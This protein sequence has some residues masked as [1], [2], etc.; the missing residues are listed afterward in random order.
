MNRTIAAL[1]QT[2]MRF[3]GVHSIA[4]QF[5]MT[6]V[7]IFGFALL[8]LMVIYFSMGA[9]A[10]SMNLAGRQRM[11][12]QMAAKEALLAAVQKSDLRAVE[13]HLTLFEQSHQVLLSGDPAQGVRAAT[14]P[15]IIE[16][17]RAIEPLWNGYKRLL[18]DHITTPHSTHYEQ[19]AEQSKRLLKETNQTVT[20]MNAA[21]D[22]EQQVKQR[23]TLFT[24][25][26]ILILVI[27]GRIF[28]VQVLMRPIEELRHHLMAV[29]QGDYSQ[30][31]Q[32][33]YPDDEVGMIVR[34]YNQ[35]LD[36]THTLIQEI[37]RAAAQVSR[38]NQSVGTMLEQTEAGVKQQQQELDRVAKAMN[39]MTLS[40][41]QISGLAVNAAQQAHHSKQSALAGDGVVAQT[42]GSITHLTDDLAAAA[43][44]MQRLEADAQQVGQVLEV[45]TSIAQQTNLLALNAAIEAARA[46]E[47]GRGFAVV[48][49][50]VR[51]LAQKTQSSTEEIRSIIERLQN[52]SQSAVSAMQS[53]NRLVQEST[54]QAHQAGE[55][56]HQIV[57]SVEAIATMNGQIVEATQGQN[58][59][60][61]EID[62]NILHITEIAHATTQKAQETV[63][64]THEIRD[65]V[66]RLEQL[67]ERFKFESRSR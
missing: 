14:D 7:T 45:I 43:E 19:I 30:K 62:H 52:Q 46:G 9:D 15:A 44:V 64:A 38:D 16:Q 28:G 60:T 49:D 57:T 24:T 26:S 42:I 4:T 1:I 63:S 51:T 59:S 13:A 41:E 40:V 56:L 66:A 5:L 21:A 58:R 34:A 23:V 11:L 53:S 47:Q 31:M 54:T 3:M 39:R 8:S 37:N 12:T 18:L 61:V 33:L 65:E 20:L 67:I 27:L 10:T 35:M 48:A 25:G 29:E 22:A 55:A 2:T 17:M 50:E 36:Q 32:S 6:Y